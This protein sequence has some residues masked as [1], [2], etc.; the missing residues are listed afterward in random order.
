MKR[1]C[2]ILLFCPIFFHA[3]EYVDVLRLGAGISLNNDFENMEE[4]TSMKS[5]KADFT[6]PIVLNENNAFIT[7]FIF[8]INNL[9]LYPNSS[10]TSLYSSTLKLGI[11]STW[12]DVWS[13]TIV[14]LPKLASDYKN[15]SKNEFYFGALGLM[16][17]KQSKNLMYKFGFYA[18]QEAFGVFATPIFGLY[19]LSPNNRF[20][21][22][23][24]LPISGDLNYGIGK[25]RVGIDYSGISRS[26]RV[27]FLDEEIQYAD[28]NS[29]EFS[30]YIQFHFFDNQILLQTKIGYATSNYAMY[31]ADEKIDLALS[32][33]RFGDSRTQL[34]PSI[35]GS[36]FLR[37]EIIYRFHIK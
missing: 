14:F 5:L 24:S 1:L 26:Y 27:N 23:L 21:M 22:N 25:H 12:S 13:S 15:F 31:D 37:A 19:Y 10:S 4:S 17:F 34:N 18:S 11:A 36:L 2:V 6:Y 3:Q 8:D 20:E 30:G 32:A 7:G 16:K 28:V 35:E 33:F 29:L 9:E